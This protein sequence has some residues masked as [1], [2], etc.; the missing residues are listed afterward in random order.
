[1]IWLVRGMFNHQ[2]LCLPAIEVTKAKRASKQA[3]MAMPA[4]A[5][6]RGSA[7]SDSFSPI[8]CRSEVEYA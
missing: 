6:S 7:A 3:M 5:A 1:M 8:R 4:K 2:E